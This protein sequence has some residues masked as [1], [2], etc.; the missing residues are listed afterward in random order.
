MANDIE[1]IDS[2]VSN[3]PQNLKKGEIESALALLKGAM[4]VV[5]RKQNE[6]QTRLLRQLERDR[7]GESGQTVLML[8]QGI[9]RFLDE[10]SSAIEERNIERKVHNLNRA[11][12]IFFELINSLDMSQGDVANYLERLYTR[13][14]QTLSQANFQND[15]GKINV[16]ANVVRGLI[17]AWNDTLNESLPK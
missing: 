3:C 16:V 10:A 8:Y 4:E 14:I 11:N 9:L 13:Q 17:D 15:K 1:K 5:T 6:L 2:L 12:A 7:L